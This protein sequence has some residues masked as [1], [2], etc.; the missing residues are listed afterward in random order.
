MINFVTTRLA[1]FILTAAFG[2]GAVGSPVRTPS[3]APRD[4]VALES[5]NFDEVC[6]VDADGQTRCMRGGSEATRSPDG[7]GTLTHAFSNARISCGF[8]EEGL[9][10]WRL[11]SGAA[12]LD[13]LPEADAFRKVLKESDVDSIQLSENNVCG[14]NSKSKSIKCLV[15]DWDEVTNGA[16]VATSK[17]EIHTFALSESALCWAERENT[18]GVPRGIESTISCRTAFPEILQ[19]PVVPNVNNLRELVVGSDWVCARSSQEAT[20]WSLRAAIRLS[21]PVLT[22][23]SWKAVQDN[24]CALE[25]NG[26]IVCLDPRTGLPTEAGSGPVVPME[27]A[28][29]NSDVDEIW[30]SDSRMCAVTVKKE[31]LCWDSWSPTPEQVFYGPPLSKLFGAG[32]EPCGLYSNGQAVCG[33]YYTESRTLSKTDRIRVEFGG[34]N[35]CFWN[36]SGVDCRGRFDSINYRSVRMIAASREQESICVVGIAADQGSEF[37]SVRCFGYPPELKSPPF[38]LSNPTSVSVRDD[39]ACAISDD[40]LTCWGGSYGGT[41]LPTLIPNPKKVVMGR[42]HAC[43]LDDFGMVCWGELTAFN[44]EIPTDLEQPGKIVDFALG[45][46]RTCVTLDTGNVECWGI[47]YE[48]SGP[49]PKMTNVKSLIGRGGLFCALD[50]T[51]VRCWGGETGLPK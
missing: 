48:L 33:I 19:F 1:G 16:F 23:K 32:S 21:L 24:L 20:C 51:R 49:P 7:V 25:P 38:E 15:P 6:G 13:G 17:K 44:L 47:D 9:K 29:P 40:G 22:A 12:L 30:G 37:E 3:A 10:C 5:L 31:A 35:K 11:P 18:P 14:T 41:E 46:S 34:Y 4:F 43:A 2:F 45:D 26:R 42:R 50:G 28:E 36:S 8:D 27:Y 39:K